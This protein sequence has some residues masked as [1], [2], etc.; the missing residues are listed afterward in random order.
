MSI[1]LPLKDAVEE[2]TGFEVI[3]IEQHYKRDMENLGAIRTLVGV[4]HA[5]EHRTNPD[6]TWAEVEQRTMRDLNGYF[7][8]P[9]VEPDDPAGKDGSG[10]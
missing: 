4:V 5:Y 7:A 10:E 1:D 6:I 8:A 2:L 9:S 3:G